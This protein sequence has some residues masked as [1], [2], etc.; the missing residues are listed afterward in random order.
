ML[1]VVR[2]I[3]LMTQGLTCGN[4]VTG[5]SGFPQVP[6]DVVR[7][8]VHQPAEQPQHRPWRQTNQKLLQHNILLT[9]KLIFRKKYFKHFFKKYSE[10]SR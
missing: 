2:E 1:T 5:L 3:I 7:V 9:K 6:Q 10:M 8:H 4:L